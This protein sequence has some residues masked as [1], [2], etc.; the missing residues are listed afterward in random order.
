VRKAPAHEGERP[1][2][3]SGAPRAHANRKGLAEQALGR[4]PLSRPLTTGSLRL[5]SPSPL[6]RVLGPF[7]PRRDPKTALGRPGRGHV[8]RCVPEPETGPLRATTANKPLHQPSSEATQRSPLAPEVRAGTTMARRA[9]LEPAGLR[10]KVSAGPATP[11]L[12]PHPGLSWRTEIDAEPAS[13]SGGVLRG[14]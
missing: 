12:P 5:F 9:G 7:L 14:P 2:A 13:A 11:W 4:H 1:E 6:G 8:V 10:R 3:P